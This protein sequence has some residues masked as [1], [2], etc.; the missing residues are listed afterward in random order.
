MDVRCTRG[1]F[2]RFRFFLLM[3]VFSA[4]C[5]VLWHCFWRWRCI[6]HWLVDG[7]IP[8]TS[9][10]WSKCTL[11]AP[12]AL[13]GGCTRGQFARFRIFFV[14]ERMF[15]DVC[16]LFLTI[17]VQCTSARIY[18]HKEAFT[19]IQT[20][21][22]SYRCVYRHVYRHLL[23]YISICRH[24]REYIGNYKH[25][26]T[27]TDIYW[28][29]FAYRGLYRN[30]HTFWYRYLQLPT[31]TCWHLQAL[32]A[33]FT[34]IYLCAWAVLG[35]SVQAKTGIDNLL[36][37]FRRGPGHKRRGRGLLLPPWREGEFLIGLIWLTRWNDS[38][39]WNDFSNVNRLLQLT[40]MS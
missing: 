14:D 1:Q 21:L 6:M 10:V 25:T 26:L 13:L 40:I 9:N 28:H 36:A 23:T 31:G 4:I 3:S 19:D 20:H 5:T 15:R 2:V 12:R 29:S 18:M 39:A 27:Y 22:Q 17:A 34:G 24:V 7:V 32:R 11:S 37:G 8:A 16:A 33:A 38:Q 35:R 30:I